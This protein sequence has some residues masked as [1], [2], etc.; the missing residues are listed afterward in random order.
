MLLSQALGFLDVIK[1]NHTLLTEIVQRV[2]KESD[3][4]FRPNVANA[5]ESIPPKML[6]LMKECWNED[7]TQR[8]S[9]NDCR[10]KIRSMNK[11]K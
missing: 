7:A 2:A 8:P 11:G 4:P 5:E 9:F 6:E 10:K 1:F 3:T